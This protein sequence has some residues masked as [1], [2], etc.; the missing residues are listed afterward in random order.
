MTHTQR[1]NW[2]TLM[3]PAACLAGCLQLESVPLLDAGLDDTGTQDVGEVDPSTDWP[4]IVQD[5]NRRI[6]DVHVCDSALLW[7]TAATQDGLGN[8]LND[9]EVWVWEV[10]GSPQ[11]LA[12]HLRPTSSPLVGCHD[13]FAY[14]NQR[15]GAL[16]WSLNRRSMSASAPAEFV[17]AGGPWTMG[18]EGRLTQWIDDPA[19]EMFDLDDSSVTLFP[20]DGLAD[21]IV[22]TRA[23]RDY[24]Y[25]ASAMG[26]RIAY[27]PDAEW[28][29]VHAYFSDYSMAAI[30]GRLVTTEAGNPES[31]V[32]EVSADGEQ[33]LV[34]AR[35]CGISGGGPTPTVTARGSWLLW[36]FSP[37]RGQQCS[38]VG[39]SAIDEH[40]NVHVQSFPE[41]SRWVEEMLD[42]VHAGEAGLIRVVQFGPQ[43]AFIDLLNGTIRLADEPP[44]PCIDP[45]LPCPEGAQCATTRCSDLPN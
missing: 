40:G 24:L 29:E 9:V 23:T 30:T 10:G 32:R 35:S 34:M 7:L 6:A 2:M 42:V 17:R 18:D 21:S 13:G 33:S 12:T 39:R 19:I 8:I 16:V 4:V 41:L 27:T 37:Q 45:T 44:F 25:I 1:L 26:H 14:W 31:Y 20:V 36:N 15:D 43:I 22:P 11:V 38:E 5:F 3:V 28:S